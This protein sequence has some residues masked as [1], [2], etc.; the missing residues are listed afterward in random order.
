MIWRPCR[1]CPHS[2]VWQNAA[3]TARS[4]P[5]HSTTY[6]VCVCFVW[7][8]RRRR[9][10]VSL[11]C[12]ACPRSGWRRPSPHPRF[13]VCCAFLSCPAVISSLS[14]PAVLF[15]CFCA[16]CG[17]LDRLSL[18]VS[19]RCPRAW[20]FRRASP[21]PCSKPRR[22]RRPYASRRSS[23]SSSSSAELANCMSM[24]SNSLS[25]GKISSSSAAQR[26]LLA[27]SCE[28]ME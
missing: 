16:L 23:S 4:S 18:S 27:L 11:P 21:A 19:L 26:C 17:S 9:A 15:L 12:R 28:L 3:G 13:R 24:A 8:R 25:T 7:S 5:S 1:S 14:L 10:P 20:A 6:M 2:L 22:R